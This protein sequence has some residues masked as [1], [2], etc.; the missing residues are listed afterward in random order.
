V[1]RIIFSDKPEGCLKADELNVFWKLAVSGQ[2]V[3]AIEPL[4]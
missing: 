1:T 2:K 3:F 4:K